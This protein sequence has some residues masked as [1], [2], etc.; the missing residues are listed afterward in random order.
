M[1]SSN[2]PQ[3]STGLATTATIVAISCLVVSGF[4]AAAF[5]GDN[6]PNTQHRFIMIAGPLVVLLGSQVIARLI[7][8]SKA[9]AWAMILMLASC[10]L[11]ES[12]SIFTSVVSFDGNLITARRDQNQSSPELRRANETI[13]LFDQQIQAAQANRNKM[14]ELWITRKQRADEKIEQ[15]IAKRQ[16][17][18]AA[19][20]SVDVSTSGAAMDNMQNSIGVSQHQIALL[21]AILLS[22]I[23]FSINLGLGSLQRSESGA[24]T[25]KKSQRP[26]LRSVA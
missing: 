26:N 21:F 17:A 19:A 18:V 20:S 14:P 2:L 6:V 1:S 25:A 11:A 8:R 7:L 13:T 12:G 5:F 23:P 3:V 9:P 24:Q 16:A 10:A 22:C 4:Q 15:L